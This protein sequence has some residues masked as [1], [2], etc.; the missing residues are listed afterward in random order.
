MPGS[1]ELAPP[2]SGQGASHVLDR[3]P[4]L[5][6]LTPGSRRRR[7]PYVQQTTATDCGAACLT[8]VLGYHGKQMRLD[9]VRS[10]MGI[11]RDG[12]DALALLQ[13]GR[14]FGLRGRGVQVEDIEDLRYV[15]RGTVLHWNFNHFV[16][17]ESLDKRGATVV[18]PGGGRRNVP[19]SELRRSFTGVALTFEPAEDFEPAEERSFGGWR[20]LKE[21]LSQSSVVTRLL[22][23][24]LALQLLA[25]A[26]P[27]LT[28]LLVD[29]VV[30]RGDY[31]LLQVLAVGLLGIVAFHFFSSLVRAHLLLQ[32][33][34]HFDAKVTLEFLDHLVDLP[35][36]FFQ[37]R[38]AGDLLMRLNSHTT[39]REILTSN[40]LSSVLDG[41]LVILYLALL[42]IGDWRL[43]L[44]VLGLGI[45]RVTLFL[46][47]RKKQRDLMS[48]SLQA[49]ATSRGYQVEMLS[50]IE[51]LKAVGAEQRA[52]E[53][54]SNLF[55]DELNVS[56]ARGRL[57]AIFDSLL[58][59][60][61]VASPLAVLVFGG[62]LVLEGGLSLGTMLAMSAL[63]TGF[64][65]PLS[66][67]VQ[68]AVQLQLMGSYLDRINDVMETEKEQDRTKAHR[69]PRLSGRITVEDV[70]FRYTPMA[71]YVVRDVSLE[72]EPGQFVA[73]VGPSGAGK[74]SL[75]KLLLGLYPP[76]EGRILFDGS[77]L[78]SLELRSLR[79]Q[80]G[81]VTQQPYL[82]GGSIRSNIALSDPTL[83]LPRIIEAAK[84][85]QIHDDI[86]V[87][88]MGYDSVLA[89]G[90]ASMSGGQRQRLALARALVTRPSIL[91]LD[92]ATSNL[93]A[94]SERAIQEELDRMRST[95]I[96]IAHRLSTI[97]AADTILVM[98][99][100]RIVEKGPHAELVTNGGLYS[101]LVESQMAREGRLPAGAES[102]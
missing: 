64:L 95:R 19:R 92:E 52:V 67:L 31:H 35:Y 27:V 10:V 5:R 33:R 7:V 98:D 42:L 84:L 58:T 79:S 12:S 97:M 36:A 66:T 54:W 38:S 1:E 80:L 14:W 55:V 102:L 63:A 65:A 2:G 4:A 48:E 89:D 40:A 99:G 32:L 50:G 53:H 17:F 75:A 100:G 91:L 30:P 21:L 51:T 13:T 85:A 23:M 8:M 61:G 11:G 70:S 56:L 15:P 88:P 68:T 78:A 72:I 74:S 57:N 49:Q 45:L 29:R 25:L 3:F 71:P 18:D 76:T 43:G 73:L 37:Q 69:A 22:V 90:G 6:Q 82:F 60:L 44:L 87:M 62:Y 94:V 26:T 41:L 101:K 9:D 93:D 46:L 86:A 96:V 81:I 47:V 59:A 28:G 24:S 20:Y 77:D 16:V 83:P 34:T 39:I